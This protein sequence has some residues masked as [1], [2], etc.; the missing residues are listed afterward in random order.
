MF[1][2]TPDLQTAP[3]DTFGGLFTGASPDSLPE[4]A[5]PRLYNVDFL[6]GGVGTRPGL[7]P[8]FTYSGNNQTNGGGS[9]VDVPAGSIAWASVGN[10]LLNTGVYASAVLA[11]TGSASSSRPG[12]RR[13]R[14][15][16]IATRSCG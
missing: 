13:S 11:S 15:A 7:D 2:I 16:G 8:L 9:A 5:S 10:V 3:L 12:A 6:V 1:T 4:G 14:A